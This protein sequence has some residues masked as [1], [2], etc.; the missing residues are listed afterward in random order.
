MIHLD[1]NALIALPLWARDGH[2]A[3][4]RIVNGEAAGVCA[5][6]WYEFVIGPMDDDEVRLARA[7]IRDTIVPIDTEDAA[8]AAALFNSGGRRRTLKTDALIAASAIRANA[9]FCTVNHVDF[10]PFIAHGL[11]LLKH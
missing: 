10:E 9:E 5:I 11:R 2:P 4:D 6:V 8:L 7:F 3:L 1:T